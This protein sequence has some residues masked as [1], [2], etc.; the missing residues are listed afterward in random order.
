MK[1]R[2]FLL[3]LAVA[4]SAA[5]M[6]EAAETFTKVHDMGPGDGTDS[7]SGLVLGIDG[8]YYGTANSGGIADAGTIF[9]LNT[10]NNLVDVLFD[11]AVTPESETANGSYPTAIIRSSD[12]Y[13][14]GTTEAGG[15]FGQGTIYRFPQSG[16]TPRTPPQTIY[17]FRCVPGA[18]GESGDPYGALTEGPDGRLYGMTF[19]YAG[20]GDGSVYKLTKP[21]GLIPAQLTVL[22][23]FTIGISGGQTFGPVVVGRDG[24]V[25]GTTYTGASGT[26]QGAI[27]RV[28]PKG[29][30]RE[31]LHVFSRGAAVDDGTLC[32]GNGYPHRTGAGIDGAA[33]RSGL[34]R[35]ADGALYG[36]TESGGDA[37]NPGPGTIFRITED[38]CFSSLRT[39]DTVAPG[40]FRPVSEMLGSG[41]GRFLGGTQLGGLYGAGGVYE[42]DSTNGNFR[43]V[44]NFNDVPANPPTLDNRDGRSPYRLNRGPNGELIGA[45]ASGGINGS[46]TLFGLAIE[47][48]IATFAPTIVA[49][50]T[51]QN[52]APAEDSTGADVTLS[53]VWSFDPDNDYPLAYRWSGLPDDTMSTAPTLSKRFPV[54]PLGDVLTTVVTLTV[55]DSSGQ[56]TTT[57]LDVVVEDT[58]PPHVSVALAGGGLLPDDSLDVSIS[59]STRPVFYL[60]MI[61]LNATDNV[62]T[63]VMPV[64]CTPL[65]GIYSFSLGS[66]TV[67]R[68]AVDEAGNIGET[69]FTLVVSSG[70]PTISVPGTIVQQAETIDGA[71]VTFDVTG[72]DANGDALSPNEI[73]CTKMVA[74]VSVELHSGVEFPFG[75]TLVTCSATVTSSEGDL[76]SEP[77]EF[78]VRV[79]DTT[80]PVLITPLGVI[81]VPS[82]SFAPPGDHGG[83]SVPF[84]PVPSATNLGQ[85][86]DVECS[87][88]T[89]RI[90]T[91]GSR[92]VIGVYTVTCTATDGVNPPSVKTFG[93]QVNDD[94]SPVIAQHPDIVV[95]GG[96]VVLKTVPFRI[97]ATDNFSPLAVRCWVGTSPEPTETTA[98]TPMSPAEPDMWLIAEM[99]FPVETTSVTC[100]ATEV[101]E[102]Y[103]AGNDNSNAMTFTVT[104]LD[105]VAPVLSLPANI[106]A[107][108]VGGGA[109]SVTFSATAVDVIEGPLPVS[110]SWPPSGSAAITPPVPP[111][112]ATGIF[113]VGVTTITCSAT[114]SSGNSTADTT[115]PKSFTV[116][117]RIGPTVTV[118]API[119]LDATSVNG[120]GV[121]FLAS[122]TTTDIPPVPVPVTCAWGSKTLIFPAKTLVLKSAT[123]PIGVTTVTCTAFDGSNP[124][125]AS[126]TITVVDQSPVVTVPANVTI[127]ASAL[128]T[129][130][131][132]FIASARDAVDGSRVC[133]ERHR[134]PVGASPTRARVGTAR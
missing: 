74:G 41:D 89:G 101:N 95:D 93:V 128:G 40:L 5:V 35:D 58:T 67:T 78:T 50:S 104:V 39:F 131:I 63:A 2:L 45:N 72:Y 42:F 13:F 10:V 20:C 85:P 105:K 124:G 127:N 81:N 52:P 69:T 59:A 16:T 76:T 4:V 112:S 75:D 11:F 14:Y 92:F 66:H 114:D 133:H 62:T 6:P 115:Q 108:L 46:G 107:A 102:H 86:V 33:P 29:G 24:S 132:T 60:P 88:D 65:S 109:T 64:T 61:E 56:S 73:E 83:A 28:P 110:C 99:K 25:F 71:H 106:T 7:R 32:I 55:T 120:A 118:P 113:P 80:P 87:D 98:G 68:E 36:T 53:A 116:T 121:S 19:G 15:E 31:I 117:V 94:I 77:E 96:D 43:V 54:G 9:R 30:S 48:P 84:D 129:A 134:E 23:N 12:G 91:S 38:G 119:T 21:S 26:P 111:A 51:P 130:T 97:M 8:N 3:A 126:F 34:V 90:V 49:T 1:T 18:Q 22:Y 44:Y 27:F 47:P 70:L 17:S 122:A 123:F 82:E 103:Y 37:T 100:L 79:V 57:T 125:S